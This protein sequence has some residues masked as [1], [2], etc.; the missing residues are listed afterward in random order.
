[1]NYSIIIPH[2]NT[3]KLLTRLLNSIPTR[4]DIEIIIVDDNSSDAIV[5][6]EEFPGI[7]KKNVTVLFSRK[8]NKGAGYAR[9]YG[10]AAAN[11]KWLMFAD[12]DDLYNK[13]KFTET[14]DKH[15][16]SDADIIFYGVEC[17]YSED[18]TVKCEKRKYKMENVI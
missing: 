2:K 8:E 15:L 7:Q 6:F 4:D 11:G 17:F 10:M 14:I 1:M 3:P 9:N 5:N 13:E 16:S 12:S 18:I